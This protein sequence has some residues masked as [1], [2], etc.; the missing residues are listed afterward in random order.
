M[1]GDVGDG[2]RHRIRSSQLTAGG[3]EPLGGDPVPQLDAHLRP[4]PLQLPYRYPVR[5]RDLLGAEVPVGEMS[6]EVVQ[7][8]LQQGLGHGVPAE[9]A[10]VGGA[11]DQGA[12][13]LYRSPPDGRAGRRQAEHLGVPAELSQVIAHQPVEGA[14]AQARGRRARDGHR[15]VQVVIVNLEGAAAARAEPVIVGGR[16]VDQQ[17]LACLEDARDVPLGHGAG[18]LPVQG[19]RDPL[20]SGHPQVAGLAGHPQAGTLVTDYLRAGAERRIG[21]PCPRRIGRAPVGD[22]TGDGRVRHR[23]LDRPGPGTGADQ[24]GVQDYRHRAS[25]PHSVSLLCPRC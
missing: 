25:S 5:R 12:H 15:D 11:H 9:R 2:T 14:P 16:Q 20:G 8:L 23:I 21:H 22:L 10:L 3:R 13:Q 7:H 6:P 19:K 18:S 1:K 24:I 4:R 17:H